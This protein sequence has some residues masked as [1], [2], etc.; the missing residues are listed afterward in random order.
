MTRDPTEALIRR[1]YDCFNAGD[2]DGMLA[3]LTDDVVHAI[4]QGARSVAKPLRS[5][6]RT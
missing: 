6:S 5:S 2:V 4:S 1:Y 3:L